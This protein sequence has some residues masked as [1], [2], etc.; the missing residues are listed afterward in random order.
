MPFLRNV[1]PITYN[2]TVRTVYENDDDARLTELFMYDGIRNY[3]TVLS[4]KVT[5]CIQ[6]ALEIKHIMQGRKLKKRFKVAI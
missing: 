6:V 2:R 5:T 3:F 4:G 1:E